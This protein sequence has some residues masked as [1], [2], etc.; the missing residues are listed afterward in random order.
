MAVLVV[1]ALAVRA[2]VV[3]V[4]LV[5][6]MARLQAAVSAPWLEVEMGLL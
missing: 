6:V 4:E 3:P 2:L 5:R 1:Q